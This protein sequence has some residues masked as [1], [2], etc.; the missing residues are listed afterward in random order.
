MNMKKQRH[1]VKKV[2]EGSIAE[3][4]N[5][6]VGDEILK[7]NDTEIED[8]FDYEYLCQD[9]YIEV[10]V[11][12]PDGEEWVLEID[13][14][15]AEPLGLEFE[16][17]LMDDYRSC[18]NHCIFCFIDQNPK[19][20]RD[21]MYFK[22][23]DSRLSF[24]QGNYIT[25]THLSDH[26]ID[27][28][29]KYRLEPINISFQTMNPELRCKMLGNRFAGE[30][31]KKVDRFYEAGIT[32]N[33]QIVLCKG[34]NDGKE[35]ED[36][37]E[38]LYKYY[39][40]LESVSV[41]PVGLSKFRDGLYPLEPFTK[42]DALDVIRIIEKFQKRAIKEGPYHFVHASDEWYIK[43]GLDMPAEETYDGYLQ[44]ENGVGMVRCFENEI[45]DAIKDKKKSPY[46]KGEVSVAVGLLD[47]EHMTMM[48]KEIEEAFPGVKINVYGIRNDFYGEMITVTGLLTGGDIMAQLKDKSIGKTLLL[49]ENMVRIS[50]DIFLD[51]VTV[52]E[53]SNAL[54]VPVTIVKSSGMDFLEKVLNA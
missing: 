48:C 29:I 40:V 38:K 54:H 35:L 41:V 19:G 44:Y 43:A 52:A 10:L 51:D 21:A 32:M 24:L 25:L 26:D 27:R 30:A 5:I 49:S 7:I 14:D 9:D 3:E 50:D 17:G 31:L 1:I 4:M 16:N 11:K 13:K 33:G 20:M 15:M 12:K 36:T 42:E 22:D 45:R 46:N 53:V 39:P 2:E 47:K 18:Y 28:M 34:I 23:D 8:I 37:L 6:E